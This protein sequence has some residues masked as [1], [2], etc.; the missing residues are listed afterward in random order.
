MDGLDLKSKI[1]RTVAANWIVLEKVF[2]EDWSVDCM[3]DH[4]KDRN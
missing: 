3:R 1:I 2:E 4:Y